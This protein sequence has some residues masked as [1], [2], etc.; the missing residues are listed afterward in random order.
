MGKTLHHES[1]GIKESMEPLSRRVHHILRNKGTG[2]DLICDIWHNEARTE[3]TSGD[4]LKAVITAAKHLKLQERVIDTEMI[5]VHSLR[6]GGSMALK[7]MGYKDS[8]IRKFGHWTSDTCQIYI[9]SQIAKL[10]E[11]VA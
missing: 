4:I 5:G 1:T 2:E 9:H 11:G 3:V 7:I 10:S 6:S 8:T